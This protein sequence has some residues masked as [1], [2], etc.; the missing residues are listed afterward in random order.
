MFR[1]RLG[2]YVETSKAQAIMVRNSYRGTISVRSI[3]CP[4]CLAWIALGATI[5]VGCDVRQSKSASVQKKIPESAGST[6]DSAQSEKLKSGEPELGSLSHEDLD[7]TLWLQ[8]SAE[9]KAI[10]ESTYQL[11][12]EKVQIGLTDP[13]WSALELQSEALAEQRTNGDS[14]E[15][16]LLQPAVILDID[17]TVL[18]NSAYQ[19][20]SIK[21]GRE[22]EPK[23]WHEFCERAE[24]KAIP[25]S[26]RFLDRCRQSG[27]AAFFL[28]NREHDV[29]EATIRNLTDQGLLLPEEKGRVLNKGQQPDWSSDKETR[30]QFVAKDYRVLVLVGDDLNDFVSVGFKPQSSE[31]RR[32]ADAQR[33]SWGRIWFILP[34]ANYGGWERAIYGWDD[35]LPRGEKLKQKHAALIL[36]N[37]PAEAAAPEPNK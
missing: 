29:T 33:D 30:R 9:Y 37:Q 4:V 19:A 18:D 36:S 17:E 22:F 11:A 20:E 12:W 13:R 15:P 7:A 1:S 6:S 21:L 2:P 14:S 32:I 3:F 5:L 35:S 8:T 25:G 24:S 26:K 27:I 10:A 34:N 16:R 31:R 23:S 28:S